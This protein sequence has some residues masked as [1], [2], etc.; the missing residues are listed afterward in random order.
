MSMRR[1]LL[2]TMLAL[3]ATATVSGPANA[4]APDQ[5]LGKGT[6]RVQNGDQ[7][8][9]VTVDVNAT[10]PTP[11]AGTDARGKLTFTVEQSVGPDAT[12]KADPFCVNAEGDLGTVVGMVTEGTPASIG[13][14]LVVR[15]IDNG[16]GKDAPPDA[17]SFVFSNLTPEAAVAAGFCQPVPGVGPVT[18]DFEVRDRT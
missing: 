9:D 16:K 8:T 12:Y 3:I 15:I 14:V 2:P 11:G 6:H 10:D 1:L 5:V 18:G 13:Q 7:F 17:F 4:A